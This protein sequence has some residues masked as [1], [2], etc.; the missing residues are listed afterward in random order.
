MVATTIVGMMR[1]GTTSKT[2]WTNSH[3]VGLED[4]HAHKLSLGHG[5]EDM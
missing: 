1:N 4:T 3:A 5:T 2:K